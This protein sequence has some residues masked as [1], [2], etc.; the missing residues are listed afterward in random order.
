MM[1]CL[2]DCTALISLVWLQDVRRWLPMVVEDCQPWMPAESAPC[3]RQAAGPDS[4]LVVAQVRKPWG[5]NDAAA[6][7]SCWDT[8]TP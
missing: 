1:V 7:A 5:S 2:G 8:S 3:V 6:A 4:N